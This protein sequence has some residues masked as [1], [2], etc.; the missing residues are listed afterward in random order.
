MEF[1]MQNYDSLVKLYSEL[2]TNFMKFKNGKSYDHSVFDIN[3]YTY[4]KSLEEEIRKNLFIDGFNRTLYFKTIRSGLRLCIEYLEGAMSQV[5]CPHE[6][7][8]QILD[9]PN[10]F[11]TKRDPQENLYDHVWRSYFQPMLMYYGGYNHSDETLSSMFMRYCSG[12]TLSAKEISEVLPI[13]FDHNSNEYAPIQ[14]SVR[15][16]QSHLGLMLIYTTLTGEKKFSKN[17]MNDVAEEYGFHSKNSGFKIFTNYFEP[18]LAVGCRTELGR[19]N[20]DGTSKRLDKAFLKKLDGAINLLEQENKYQALEIAFKEKEIF[21][22]NFD[23]K[24]K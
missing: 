1:Q 13:D 20:P 12:R 4:I 23:R 22:Q 24:Y 15:P 5:K 18:F 3:L 2:K 11:E 21:Q 8:Y 10:V 16:H 14:P 6:Y 7:K 19:G 9:V 17:N